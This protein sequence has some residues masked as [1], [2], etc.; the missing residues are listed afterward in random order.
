M[1]QK[2]F[3]IVMQGPRAVDLCYNNYY[4]KNINILIDIKT[5]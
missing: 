1:F 4:L 2:I 5:I 3:K